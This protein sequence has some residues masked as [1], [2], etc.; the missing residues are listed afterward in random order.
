MDSLRRVANTLE[1]R[2]RAVE[3]SNL[4]MP[5]TTASDT[6]AEKPAKSSGWLRIRRI[7]ASVLVVVATVL[8]GV[9]VGKYLALVVQ[10]CR[11]KSVL[12]IPVDWGLAGIGLSYLFGSL[13]KVLKLA[14][15]FRDYIAKP[16]K[17]V[18]L[19][20]DCF[21][22]AF[23]VAYVT[24]L[25]LAFQAS[26]EC[27]KGSESVEVASPKEIVYL[28]R[29][30]RTVAAPLEYVPFLFKDL[31][32]GDENPTKGTTLT[33]QQVSDIERL[34]A[35]LKACVGPSRGQDVEIDVRGYADS[36][37]FASNSEEQNRKTA[38]RRAAALH[39]QLKR[40]VGPQ[41]DP[42]SLILLPL[43]ES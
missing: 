1:G 2:H 15:V 14:N 30:Q 42:A 34:A 21:A 3:H 29:M 38:N 16:D 25:T 6:T 10:D 11:V 7:I 43:T 5:E 27:K 8:V 26:V 12:G 33:A 32:A 31:A 36:N 35:S 37:E 28:S 19:Y 41:T 4:T 23:I 39:E 24:V 13:E 18:S 17:K 22:L 9:F 40:L 20:P